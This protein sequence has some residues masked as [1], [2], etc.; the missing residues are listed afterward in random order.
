MPPCIYCG[1]TD[2]SLFKKVEHVVPQSFGMFGSATPTLKCVC[3]PCNEFFGK[4]LDQ[5]F[6]RDSWEGL[7]R[8]RSGML[9]REKRKHPRVQLTLGDEEQ[10]GDFAGALLQDVDGTK[11]G[12]PAPKTQFQIKNKKTGKYEIYPIEK[13]KDFKIDDELY[14]KAGNREV[15]IISHID[16]RQAV[17]DELKKVGVEY[18]HKNDFFPTFAKDGNS[19]LV[20]A[21]V[22]VDHTIKR[23]YAK[24]ILNTFTW[25]SGRSAIMRGKWDKAR[26]YVRYS[27]DPLKARMSNKPFWGEESETMRFAGDHIN[28]MVENKDGN[29]IG[30]IQFFN[31]YIYEF[32]LIENYSLP[33]EQEFAVRFTR[34]EPPAFGEKRIVPMKIS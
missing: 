10:L 26:N 14:G 11:G 21:T 28:V 24:I 19:V 23:A 32:I 30:K 8:Y 22:T 27:T 29:V 31:H 34:N 16:E 18:R 5:P 4:E 3:D 33:P 9:S 1:T 12:L 6:A 13:I 17:I 7:T 15:R 25:R 20:E 2:T